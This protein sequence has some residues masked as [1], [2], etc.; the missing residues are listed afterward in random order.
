MLQKTIFYT[1]KIWLILNIVCPLLFWIP[2][3]IEETDFSLSSML[4]GLVYTVIIG[5]ALSVPVKVALFFALWK[6]TTRKPL[7]ILIMGILIFG[8]F[9]ILD[10]TFMTEVS[11]LVFPSVYTASFAVLI[12]I[13]RMPKINE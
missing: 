2:Q 11:Y 5:L 8:T 12:Y 7:R 13:F 1:L 4:G 3:I 10:G 9:A 6:F